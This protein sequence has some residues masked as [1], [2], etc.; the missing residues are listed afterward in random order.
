MSKQSNGELSFSRW[1]NVVLS[2]L[3]M[4]ISVPVLLWLVAML[5]APGWRTLMFES[6]LCWGILAI[7]LVLGFSNASYYYKRVKSKLTK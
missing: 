2:F 5:V 6:P 4:A 3:F 1:I 7:S